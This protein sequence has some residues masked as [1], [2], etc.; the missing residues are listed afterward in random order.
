VLLAASLLFGAAVR[1]VAVFLSDV[2]SRRYLR[3]RDLAILFAAAG[4]E[5]ADFTSSMRGGGAS[6]PCRR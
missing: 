6:E 1:L 2:A 3:G 4:L 5:N